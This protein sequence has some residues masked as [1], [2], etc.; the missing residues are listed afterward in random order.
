MVTT[1]VATGTGYPDWQGSST[2]YYN[3]CTPVSVGSSCQTNSPNFRN[4]A[5]QDYRLRVPS[6]CIDKGQYSSWMVGATDYV[7][8]PRIDAGKLV[9]IGAI[10]NQSGRAIRLILR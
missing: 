6:S 2:A 9:D 7:G 10:E 1:N 5:A 3:C 4:P 8:K